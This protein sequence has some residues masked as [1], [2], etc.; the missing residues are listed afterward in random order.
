[1]NSLLIS[2]IQLGLYL[3]ASSIINAVGNRNILS[4]S[5]LRHSRRC[6]SNQTEMIKIILTSE[7]QIKISLNVSIFRSTVFGL[8]IS[9][10]CGISLYWAQDT[11]TILLLSAG[12]ISIASISSTTLVGSIVSL[13][14]TSTR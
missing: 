11:T 9:G 1:M 10:S 4:K 5:N 13:F 14:P 3:M 6:K 12:Y 2:L 8:M 7:V